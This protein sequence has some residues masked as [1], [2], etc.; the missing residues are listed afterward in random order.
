MN[1]MFDLDNPFMRALSTMA[2]LM[3]LNLWVTVCCI[4]VFTA[5][6]AF[7]GM[8]YVLLKMVRDEEGYITKSFFKSFKENFK[9]ATGHWLMM[10][11]LL[12]VFA[13]DFYIFRNR[14]DMFP[15]VLMIAIM[16][17][18]IFIYLAST[19]VFPLQSHFE[20]TVRGTIKN[21]FSLMILHLP[22]AVLMAVLYVLPVIG[23][24]KISP[25]LYPILFMFGF[26]A[27][28][29]ACAYLYSRIFKKFEPDTESEIT[30]DMDFSVAREGDTVKDEDKEDKKED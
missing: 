12:A 16:A 21:A 22:T 8:H 15:K 23:F 29:F 20:N 5:G 19:F 3:I 25:Y 10:L 11:V 14:P 26:S 17:I 28:A 1:K 4:P 13:G 18:G 7:T 30:S 27:P 9:Q 2:D 24:L 6:A